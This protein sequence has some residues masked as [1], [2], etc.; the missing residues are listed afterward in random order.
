MFLS[1]FVADTILLTPTS[2]TNFTS[3]LAVFTLGIFI[4][5]RNRKDPVHQ[6]AFAMALF[7]GFWAMSSTLS[8]VMHEPGPALFWARMSIIGPYF[9]PAFFLIFSYQFP[10]PNGRMRWWK[11]A[12]I[13][14]PSFVAMALLN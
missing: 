8:D 6:L 3:A 11:A 2:V 9:F 7:L 4:Y 5:L 14:L 12:L 1:T 10:V 13:L